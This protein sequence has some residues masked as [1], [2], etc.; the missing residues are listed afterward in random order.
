MN[1]HSRNT[2]SD[3]QFFP[4]TEANVLL[5]IFYYNALGA[6]FEAF[7]Q[8]TGGYTNLLISHMGMFKKN[9]AFYYFESYDHILHVINDLTYLKDV[10]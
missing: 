8:R 9:E 10:F 5:R 2:I 1:K 7:V 6:F 4:G 3:R